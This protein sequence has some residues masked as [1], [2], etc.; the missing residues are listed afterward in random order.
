MTTIKFPKS[1]EEKPHS[2]FYGGKHWTFKNEDCEISIVGGAR[3]LYGD[4]VTTFEYWDFAEN[5]PE[6]WLS[7]EE[8]NNRLNKYNK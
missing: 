2:V 6:G 5:G 8:I 1:F 4:G 3:G 7:I